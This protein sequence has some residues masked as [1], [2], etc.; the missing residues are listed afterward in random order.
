M[1]GSR[2]EILAPAGQLLWT[3]GKQFA[4]NI[5]VP[6]ARQPMLALRAQIL[7]ALTEKFL[8]PSMAKGTASAQTDFSTPITIKQPVRLAQSDVR[9]VK[10]LLRGVYNAQI[11]LRERMWDRVMRVPATKATMMFH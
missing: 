10:I 9:H 6:H 3:E 5:A 8:S 7:P 11:T 1:E 4:A 2:T